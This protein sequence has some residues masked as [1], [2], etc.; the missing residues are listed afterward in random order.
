MMIKSIGVKYALTHH[1]YLFFLKASKLTN[2]TNLYLDFSPDEMFISLE[3]IDN[4]SNSHSYRL[5]K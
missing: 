2:I 1:V 4:I 5:P 3:D